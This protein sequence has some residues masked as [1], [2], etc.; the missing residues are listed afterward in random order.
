M[1]IVDIFHV[2]KGKVMYV[3]QSSVLD[4]GK[5]L[6]A[7]GK[8]NSLLLSYKSFRDQDFVLQI[9]LM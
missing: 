6:Y 7:L 3:G 9:Y 8:Q 4:V 1:T 2:R 5:S